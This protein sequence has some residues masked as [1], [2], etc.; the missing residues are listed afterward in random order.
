MSCPQKSVLVF[1]DFIPIT[2]PPTPLPKYF[3][4]TSPCTEMWSCS[5]ELA[6]GGRM[7]TWIPEKL[8]VLLLS[9]EYR[10]YAG[11]PMTKTQVLNNIRNGTA[12]RTEL[13]VPSRAAQPKAQSDT[14]QSPVRRNTK[15]CTLESCMLM[16]TKWHASQSYI[17]IYGETKCNTHQIQSCKHKVTHTRVCRNVSW[18]TPGFVGTKVTH[19]RVRRN[20]SWHTPGYLGTKVTHARACRNK[21][22]KWCTPEASTVE[23]QS[24]TSKSIMH[25]Y[26]DTYVQWL[27]SQCCM[28]VCRVTQTTVQQVHSQWRCTVLDMCN[29]IH[30]ITHHCPVYTVTH[31]TALHVCIQS[32]THHSIACMYTVTHITFTILCMDTD[33]HT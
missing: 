23:T 1:S 11:A 31:I 28:Y 12:Y 19:T 4:L 14:H 21:R 17:Y 33:W 20:V 9:P 29:C 15:W 7:M 3:S 30:S 22:T 10:C 32:N 16:S 18:H 26:N 6:R 24:D 27:I 5:H 8:K 2:T 13:P 25:V